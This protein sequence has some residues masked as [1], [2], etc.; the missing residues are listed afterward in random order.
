[1]KLIA[2]IFS[3]LMLG[4]TPAG[5]VGFQWAM[6]PDPDGAP[7]AVAIWYPSD[8]APHPDAGPLPQSVAHD[9]A[10]AGR[11]L[12]LI[13]LSHGTG[14]SPL[15]YYDTAIALAEAGFVVAGPLHAGDNYRDHS[16]A[17]TQRNFAG[18]PRQI[19]RVI[20]YML[21]GWPA[22]AAIDPARIGILGHSAGGATA[23]LAIGGRIDPARVLEFCRITPQDWGCRMG[24]QRGDAA[25]WD[26][27]APPFGGRDPRIKAAVLAAPALADSYRGAVPDMPVQIWVSGKDEVVTDA[28]MAA[29][30]LPEAAYHLV[31]GAGHFAM[32]T[33]CGAM[34]AE[35]A[36]E[37]CHDPIG[38]DRAAFLQDFHAAVVSFFRAALRL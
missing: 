23:F 11:H 2:I 27:A 33:P 8:A 30:V 35:M 26:A 16:V 22:H 31:D 13:L 5:A 21:A 10:V 34:L 14:G 7:L 38:F 1:M 28:S 29:R 3:V 25:A 20:D 17:L 6:A 4:G 9:S 32:L 15:N 12:P 37:I 24:R 18:R 36:S 19:S